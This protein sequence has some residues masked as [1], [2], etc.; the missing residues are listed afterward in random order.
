MLCLTAA[1]PAKNAFILRNP[2]VESKF[3][4]IRGSRGAKSWH[5]AYYRKLRMDAAKRKM[6]LIR[7]IHTAEI[8]TVAICIE[9]S[10]LLQD[11]TVGFR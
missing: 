3:P 9:T 5:K 2:G 4:L 1:F 7:P 10:A 6:Q 8:A 11:A